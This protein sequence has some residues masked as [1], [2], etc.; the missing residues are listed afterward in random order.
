MIIRTPERILQQDPEH[1]KYLCCIPSSAHL[2][3]QPSTRTQAACNSSEQ[4][5][6]IR[7]PVECSIREHDIELLTKLE[8]TGIHLDKGEVVVNTVREMIPGK[9]DHIR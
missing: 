1:L 3:E 4:W 2:D 7:D 8:V 6:V 9:P 5:F